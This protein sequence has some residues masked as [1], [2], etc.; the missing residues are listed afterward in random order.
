MS[1]ADGVIVVGAGGHAKVVIASLAAA[2]R[3]V[4]GV[5]DDDQ[6]KVGT[7]VLGVEVVGTPEAAGRDPSLDAVIAIGDNRV[8]KELVSRL[9]LRWATVIHPAAVVHPSARVGPGAVIFAGAVVQPDAVIGAH[10]IINTGAIVEH[11]CV[12]GDFV[13]VAPGVVLAGNV[14]VG[15][16]A[17]LGIGAAVIPGARV[18]EWS[19]VGAGGVVISDVPRWATV[20]GV[21]ATARGGAGGVRHPT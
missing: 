4:R 13:H 12:I 9:A 14:W 17:L 11:D 6:E 8:R 3:P 1:L 2:G 21:P 7:R 19:V 10:A 5:Y 18:G 15:E 20:V 16:G